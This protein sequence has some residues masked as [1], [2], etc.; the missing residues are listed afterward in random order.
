M[1]SFQ[2]SFPAVLT[3]AEDCLGFLIIAQSFTICD[4]AP[5]SKIALAVCSVSV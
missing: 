3:E 1:F 5:E 4:E 2:F